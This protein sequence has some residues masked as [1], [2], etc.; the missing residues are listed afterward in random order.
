MI[1][2][3]NKLKINFKTLPSYSCSEIKIMIQLTGLGHS[4]HLINLYISLS[5]K[6]S[7]AFNSFRYPLKEN[8]IFILKYLVPKYSVIIKSSHIYYAVFMSKTSWKLWP[9]HFHK[10]FIAPS[11]DYTAATLVQALTTPTTKRPP[12]LVHIEI[13]TNTFTELNVCQVLFWVFYRYYH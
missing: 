9:W 8:I 1:L 12:I 5:W 2:R 6:I 13:I 11:L 7:D 3:F 10:D 4:M